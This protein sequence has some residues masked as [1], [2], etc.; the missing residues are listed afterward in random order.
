MYRLA[1]FDLDGTLADTSSWYMPGGAR[2]FEDMRSAVVTLHENG[3][4]LSIATMMDTPSAMGVVSSWDVGGLFSSVR[5]A[6]FP[7][8]KGDLIA[9]CVREA[10]VDPKE[11]VM[12]GDNWSDLTGAARAGV[13]FLVAPRCEESDLWPVKACR[14]SDGEE[15]AR[16]IAVPGRRPITD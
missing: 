6:D 12:V 1:I 3:V 11:A 14:P 13:D 7:C 15:L 4:M 9:M 2:I 8:D 10:R 5:G 16:M